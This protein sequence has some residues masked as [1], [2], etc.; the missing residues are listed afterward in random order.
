MDYY[1]MKHGFS[2][3]VSKI[4]RVFIKCTVSFFL[5]VLKLKKSVHLCALI[6]NDIV[7]CF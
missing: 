3:I 2:H 7:F 4:L 1:G 6:Y 5:S